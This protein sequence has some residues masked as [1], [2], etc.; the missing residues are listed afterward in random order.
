MLAQPIS[1]AG[2]AGNSGNQAQAYSHTQNPDEAKQQGAYE[3][4]RAGILRPKYI[5]D[6]YIPP[7]VRRPGQRFL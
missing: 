3:D 1:F 7:V 6:P 2:L 5:L 4:N